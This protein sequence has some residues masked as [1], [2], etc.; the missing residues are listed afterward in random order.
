MTEMVPTSWSKMAN[1]W[2]STTLQRNRKKNEN[3]SLTYDV[4]DHVNLKSKSI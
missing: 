2:A 4:N 3:I 1:K